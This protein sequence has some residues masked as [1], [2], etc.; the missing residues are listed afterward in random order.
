M[1]TDAFHGSD[2]NG[3]T[4]DCAGTLPT[5]LPPE[6]YAQLCPLSVYRKRYVYS[7]QPTD[8]LSSYSISTF[9]ILPQFSSSLPHP[10]IRPVTPAPVG[11]PD[12]HVA[13]RQLT[14]LQT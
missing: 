1:I 6:H 10:T 2:D 13:S 4:V 12:S 11:K 14:V 3:S 9:V 5:R 7:G 8:L